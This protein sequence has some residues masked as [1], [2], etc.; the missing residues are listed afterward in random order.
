[1]SA[2]TMY[3]MLKKTLI[4]GT[5]SLELFANALSKQT[6][7][8]A[9]SIN[10]KSNNFKEFASNE[11]ATSKELINEV[12]KNNFAQ[13]DV[14]DTNDYINQDNLEA[15]YLVKNNSSN[16]NSVD[17]DL[18]ISQDIEV[19][20]EEKRQELLRAE[21][22]EKIQVICAKNSITYKEFNIFA[23]VCIK[24]AKVYSESLNNYN[25]VYADA[26]AT[27]NAFYNRVH[28]NKWR[29]TVNNSSKDNAGENIYGQI[30]APGQSQ[31]YETNAYTNILNVDKTGHPA[32]QAVIDMLYT[33]MPMHDYLSF[34]AANCDP[35]NKE[36]FVSGGNLY[37][38]KLDYLDRYI[39][40][41]E[42]VLVLARK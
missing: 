12:Y 24:E 17:Y 4:M 23:C 30:T 40:E 22:Q 42:P 10:I 31:V 6:A 3:L 38:D 18:T 28:S 13:P 15:S 14:L 32:Y 5:L 1:M 34:K 7:S 36:Q 29:V 41:D 26:Y 11:L 8:A 16:T 9:K 27:T 37:H 21:N 35:N 39:N 33:E 2:R 25:E 19:V 20:D